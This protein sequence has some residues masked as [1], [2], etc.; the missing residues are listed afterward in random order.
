MTV[1]TVR[2]VGHDQLSGPDVHTRI[3][4]PRPVARARVLLGAGVAGVAV[5]VLPS[6]GIGYGVAVLLLLTPV[7][8][9]ACGGAPTWWARLQLVPILAIAPWIAIRANQTIHSLDVAACLGLLALT[10]TSGPVARA[11]SLSPD[12]PLDR[13]GHGV[14]S[15]VDGPR[16]VGAGVKLLFVRRGDVVKAVIRGLLLA[17]PVAAIVIALLAS[18]DRSFATIFAA[19][20][21]GVVMRHSVVFVVGSLVFAGLVRAAVTPRWPKSWPVPSL[22]RLE[23]LSILSLFVVIYSAFVGARL[24][25]PGDG[26]ASPFGLADQARAGFFQLLAVA[27]I[28]VAVLWVVRAMTG[29]VDGVIAGLVVALVGLT[30]ALVG[31]ALH[32]LGAYQDV[33]GLTELRLGT[34]WFSW[35]LGVVVVLAGSSFLLPVRRGRFRVAITAT[36]LVWLVAW[37]ASNPDDQ[38]AR[39]NL[40]RAIEGERFDPELLGTLSDD[41]VPVILDRLEQLEVEQQDAVLAALCNHRETPSDS[42]LGTDFST[43]SARP[44]LDRVCAERPGRS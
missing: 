18:A 5:D 19:G 37:N 41:A 30:L 31:I 2:P 12:G 42:G 39:T 4:T 21:L 36:A 24:V 6:G 32:R 40:Q 27:A 15:V 20:D 14:R 26:R 35:W 34:T 43:E 44:R 11:V 17:L 28:T 8:L 10:A 9:V 13:A 25:D 16:Y 29:E 1:D 23:V 38:I 33:F 22:G 7:L 3:R